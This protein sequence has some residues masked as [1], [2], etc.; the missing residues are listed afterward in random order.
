MPTNTPMN[1]RVY[2][3]DGP[4][5]GQSM[6]TP[7]QPS[8]LTWDDEHGAVARRPAA[9]HGRA[10]VRLRCASRRGTTPRSR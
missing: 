7:R 5:R 1:Q 2:F 4:A 8:R 6:L 10:R 3:I 9:R